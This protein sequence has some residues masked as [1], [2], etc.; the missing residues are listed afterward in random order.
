MSKTDPEYAAYW[1][2]KSVVNEAGC[3]VWTGWQM[4]FRNQKPGQPGYAESSY[5]NKKVRVHRKM[6]EFKLG[7]ALEPGEHACHA[8]DNPPCINP[9]HLYPATNQQN[10]LDGGRRKR[11]QGQDKT[12]CQN[13]H[14]LTPENTYLSKR[15][16]SYCRNC[17]TCQRI[18]QRIKAGW[19]R[20]LALS[21]E[22]VPSGQRPVGASWR[23]MRTDVATAA[24]E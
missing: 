1:R 8:C 13:G 12:H 5:H 16:Q 18:R 22:R 20:E 4:R 9:D 24:H 23:H 21:A 6:L 15:G 10:H 14:E 7:R 3:W 11:M 17:R 19:P 2:A